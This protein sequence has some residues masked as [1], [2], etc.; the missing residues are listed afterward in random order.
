MFAHGTEGEVF[1]MHLKVKN[2]C[3]LT[4][5]CRNTRRCFLILKILPSEQQQQQQSAAP[6]LLG[7]IHLSW[8]ASCY[9]LSLL[10]VFLWCTVRGGVLSAEAS[11]GIC[12]LALWEG[13]RKCSLW[14]SSQEVQVLNRE[15]PQAAD[16]QT[17]GLRRNQILFYFF[18]RI[19]VLRL[20]KFLN[21]FGSFPA[22]T[23]S[24]GFKFT[25][26]SWTLH[27]E[28]INTFEPLTQILIL[29]K[30]QI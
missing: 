16:L 9:C 21:V 22:V 23:D 26:S 27:D 10:I 5:K 6:L 30:F 8:A 11:A 29:L 14:T 13:W 12:R 7:V 25:F 28:A 1:L 4:W 3:R 17:R 18:W 2:L 15:N 19:F 20:R 24:C